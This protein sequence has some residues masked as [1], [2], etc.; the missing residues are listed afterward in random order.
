MTF[1]E[2]ATKHPPT[3]RQSGLFYVFLD[4]NKD[5]HSTKFSS[6]NSSKEFESTCFSSVS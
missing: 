6:M 2:K 5:Y 3:L 1:S 4:S